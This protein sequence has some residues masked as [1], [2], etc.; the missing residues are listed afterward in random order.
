MRHG[1][2]PPFGVAFFVALHGKLLRCT[3]FAPF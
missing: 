3:P 2:R 1:K